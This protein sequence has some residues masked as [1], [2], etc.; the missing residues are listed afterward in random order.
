MDLKR[1]HGMI[2]SHIAVSVIIH[3]E[4]QFAV[5]RWVISFHKWCRILVGIPLDHGDATSTTSKGAKVAK[6]PREPKQKHDK[7]D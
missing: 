4:D 2:H 6:H 1:K 5:R 7:G 3:A